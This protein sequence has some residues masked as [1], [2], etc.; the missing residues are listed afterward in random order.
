MSMIPGMGKM[1][2]DM[3]IDENSFKGVEAIILS[4][5]PDERKNPDILNGSRKKRIAV[6]SGNNI[7]EVNKLVKQF[8]DTR[9]VMKMVNSGKAKNLM[10]GLSRPGKR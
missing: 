9:K 6:G 4:M 3:D 1:V 7:Q 8:E 2:K 5:T 10:Q